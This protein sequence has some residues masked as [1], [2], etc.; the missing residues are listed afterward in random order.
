MKFD[1]NQRVIYKGQRA[2]IWDYSV[3]KNTYSIKPFDDGDM[4]LSDIPEDSIKPIDQYGMAESAQRLATSLS[5]AV[6]FQSGSDESLE[7]GNCMVELYKNGLLIESAFFD[8]FIK[9][10]KNQEENLKV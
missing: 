10:V 8:Y 7:L 3:R 6:R 4:L 2:I 1:L 5:N 9:E